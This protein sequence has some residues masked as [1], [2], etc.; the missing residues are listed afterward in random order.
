[1][2]EL[3]PRFIESCKKYAH[4]VLANKGK[5]YGPQFEEIFVDTFVENMHEYM[6]EELRK[7]IYGTGE[8]E[9]IGIINSKAV[10]KLHEE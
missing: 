4:K 1:M 9:P 6:D 8:D 7:L 3:E 2:S 10:V 5:Y